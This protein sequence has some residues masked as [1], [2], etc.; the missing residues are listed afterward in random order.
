MAWSASC[1]NVGSS[2]ISSDAAIVDADAA[3][4]IADT[5]KLEVLWLRRRSLQ[6]SACGEQNARARACTG[7]LRSNSLGALVALRPNNLSEN[8]IFT[9]ARRRKLSSRLLR[10]ASSNGTALDHRP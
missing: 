7:S 9:K 3:S 8:I 1:C 10:V 2:I 6:T 5:I 4:L